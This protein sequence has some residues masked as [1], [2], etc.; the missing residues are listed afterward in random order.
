M[1][2]TCVVRFQRTPLH[3]CVIVEN[4]EAAER[5]VAAGADI[6][7]KVDF[8]FNG[9]FDPPAPGKGRKNS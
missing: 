4:R 3:E 9:E 6:N 1:K 8:S 5:L 2:A 7:A